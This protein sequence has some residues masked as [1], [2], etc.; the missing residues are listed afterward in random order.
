LAAEVELILKAHGKREKAI[1]VL[2]AFAD[3][4]FGRMPAAIAVD[5]DADRFRK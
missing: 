5:V 4:E 3:Q 1:Q 2:A